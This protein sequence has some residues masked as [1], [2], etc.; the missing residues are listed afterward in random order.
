MGRAAHAPRPAPLDN[1]TTNPAVSNHLPTLEREIHALLEPASATLPSRDTVEYTLTAGYA[2]ALG[3]E[4]D[5][6]RAQQR[7]RTLIRSGGRAHEVAT[8]GG[9]VARVERELARLRA[10]L[11]TLRAHAL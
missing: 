9:E 4:G 5:R 1:R 8:A 7:L 10:L 6:L 11:A 2:H 3:L